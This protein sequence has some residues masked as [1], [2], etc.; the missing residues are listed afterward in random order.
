MGIVLIVHF[1]G[2]MM[3]AGGGFASGVI[4]RVAAKAP[5]ERAGP[6]RSVGPMLARLSTI[7]L[8]L[9]WLSGLTLVFLYGGFDALPSLFWVKAVFILTLTIA[10]VSIEVTYAQIKAGNVKAAARLP[11]LGPMAGISSLLAVVFAVLAFH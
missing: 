4:A 3:G 2:L 11:V 6:L 10:G 8:V 7:G 1:L 5:P 9:M